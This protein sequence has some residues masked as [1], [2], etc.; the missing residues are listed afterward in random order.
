MTKMKKFVGSNKFTILSHKLLSIPWIK[1][2]EA[3]VKT[4]RPSGNYR[5]S[6]KFGHLFSFNYFFQPEINF[7]KHVKQFIKGLLALITSLTDLR[8]QSPNFGQHRYL[9]SKTKVR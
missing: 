6:S 3:Q 2:F 7:F 8:F 1:D 9:F 5:K 4:I